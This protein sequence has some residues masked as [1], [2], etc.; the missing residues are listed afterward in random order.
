MSTI[1]ANLQAIRRRISEALQGDSRAVTLLAVS[2]SQP[3]GRIRE[4]HAAGC[5]HFGENY[6]QEAIAK[7]GE[8]AGLSATW[9][10]IGRV[11]TN[12]AHLVAT[13]F[14]WVH[15]IDAL[16][17]AAALSKARDG[18]L[19]LNVCIQVNISGEGSKG[20]VSPDLA[21]SLAQEVAALPGLRLRGLMGMASFTQDA[22]MQRRQF[23]TLRTTFEALRGRGLDVDTLSMGMSGD[24]EAAI[25]EGATLVRIG[26]AIFGERRKTEAA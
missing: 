12:K 5:G 3:A 7:M 23:A 11:Q 1:A 15:G 25:A 26:T 9:H 24:L 4:A 8:L 22:A 19:P 21:T 16:R 17:Q 18:R 20:G 6:V 13:H 10:Y 2:K 14:D